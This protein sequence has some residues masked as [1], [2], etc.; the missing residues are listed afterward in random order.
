[1]CNLQQEETTL[2][3]EKLQVSGKFQRLNHS[4]FVFEET[5]P[6]QSLLQYDILL[7]STLFL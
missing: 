6:R 3:G 1:M 5:H 2:L 4:I 7:A